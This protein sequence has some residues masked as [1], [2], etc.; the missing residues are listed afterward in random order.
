M[1]VRSAAAALATAGFALSLAACGGKSASPLPVT[2]Q[3]IQNQK[4]ALTRQG[5]VTAAGSSLFH[6]NAEKYADNGSHPVTGR[7]GSAVVQSRALLAKDNS[8]LVEA[9][10]G[11]LDGAAGAGN[12]RH[13]SVTPS[14]NSVND[15]T[16]VYNNLK[17]GGY[18]SH[19]YTGLAHNQSVRVDTNVTD[20]DPRTDVVT[21]I[22]T[23]KK[24]PDLS[25]D[26]TGPA[27]AYRNRPVNFVAHVRELNGDVGARADCVLSVDG[28]PVDRAQAIWV[29]AGGFVACSFTA[30]FAALGNHQVNVNVGNVVP[31]DWDLS[32]N[33]AST[34]IQ[35]VD[36][37]VHLSTSVYADNQTYH[38]I[39][40]QKYQY[41]D[42]YWYGSENQTYTTHYDGRSS[43][44]QIQGYTGQQAPQFPIA[45]FAAGVTVNGN[46]TFAQDSSTLQFAA[47]YSYFG[48]TCQ[49]AYAP[50]ADAQICAY[51]NTTSVA[52]QYNASD[53]TYYS[54]VSDTYCDY[55]WG[56]S[57]NSWVYGSSHGGNGLP[58]L[59]IGQPGD[60]AAFAISVTDAASTQF[61]GGVSGTTRGRGAYSD[62]ANYCYTD[63]WYYDDNYC[64]NYTRTGTD[65]NFYGY[66][67]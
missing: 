42:Y 46:P 67:P 58:A 27:K 43:W 30:T 50:G 14:I 64:E 31:G 44:L 65:S 37:I 13:V 62:S 41:N 3:S 35:I 7:S 26:I 54:T 33:T 28:S 57:T 20:L 61:K 21:T 11:T 9:T 60:A 40:V 8:T 55:Y 18:W 24:R 10:T 23:V 56:C 6:P 66:N 51:G 53:A 34:T 2:S 48:E 22:D 19:T 29:D 4:P 12:F 47:P 39:D 32:N 25:T 5:A 45:S 1:R 16:V 59:D 52:Y 15:T 63:G 38:E 49:T 17:A 36:P